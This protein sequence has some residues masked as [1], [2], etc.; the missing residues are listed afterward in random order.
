[1]TKQLK[2]KQISET[3][4]SVMYSAAGKHLCITSQHLKMVINSIKII[5]KWYDYSANTV[6]CA[7]RNSY[8]ISV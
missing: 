3:D 1:M 6:A 7:Y 2:V 4:N 5:N 8:R